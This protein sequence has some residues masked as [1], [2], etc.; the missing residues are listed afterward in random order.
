MT[1]DIINE[2]IQNKCANNTKYI[3]EK[4]TCINHCDNDGKYKFEFNDICYE[5]C[6]ENTIE[7]KLNKYH[8]EQKYVGNCTINNM[9]KNKCSSNYNEDLGKRIVDEILK[10]NLGELL[11]EV[12]NS[13][14]DI[15]FKENNITY[16]ISSYNYQRLNKNL[17]SVD[18][19]KCESLLRSKYG[20]L[21]EELIIYKIE[22]SFEG[23]NIP[24]IEYIL[25]SQN[26]SIS[27]NL[28]LCDDIPIKLDIPVS[29]NENDKD[30]YDPSSSYYND[31]CKKYSSEGKVDMTLFERKN[32]FNNNNMSLCEAKCTFIGYNSSNSKAMCNCHIKNNVTYSYT[33][34][35]PNDLLNKIESEKSI[36]NLGVTQ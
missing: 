5:H 12:I 3:P 32:E 24:I 25:F 11:K 7:S 8:C 27:L 19:G 10:G 20:I 14:S 4:N 9:F 18:L 34:I 35:N 1:S 2:T 21:D 31:I 16:Q 33:D 22:H 15:T 30:K 17:S 23:F 6:P 13:N 29:I 28:S 36:S 26:G